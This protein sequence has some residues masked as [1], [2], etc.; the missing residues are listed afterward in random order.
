MLLLLWQS[1]KA[2]GLI[3]LLVLSRKRRYGR[4]GG[5]RG[6]ALLET[7]ACGLGLEKTRLRLESS[8]LRL[9]VSLD[10]LCRVSCLL[11]NQ[12]AR[13]KGGLLRKLG[14]L[15]LL[16]LGVLLLVETGLDWILVAGL[17]LALAPLR[18]GGRGASGCKLKRRLRRIDC[19][20]SP[21]PR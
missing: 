7:E 6:G 19:N 15:A 3:L 11:R 14:V 8:L 9:L 10:S 20:L 17:W 13:A 21:P 4:N 5:R 2:R 16:K 12:P 18:H 1:E